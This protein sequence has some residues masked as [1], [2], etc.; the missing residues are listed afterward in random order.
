MLYRGTEFVSTFYTRFKTTWREIDAYGQTPNFDCGE[1]TCN[2]NG[3]ISEREDRLTIR[4]FLMG[5]NDQFRQIR[6]HILSMETNPNLNKVFSMVTHEE[7]Q[8]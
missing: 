6:S 8:Q 1:C 4:K 2:V 7:T 5:L 3:R